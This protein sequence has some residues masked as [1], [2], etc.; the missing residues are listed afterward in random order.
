LAVS[1]LDRPSSLAALPDGRLLIAEHGGRIRI[2]DGGQLREASALELSVT[3]GDDDGG[4][5]IAVAPDFAAN[6]YV[7]V[8]YATRDN[9]GLRIG[10]VAR[11]REVAGTL[12]EPAVVLEGLPAEAG[13]PLMKVGPDGTLFVT[14]PARNAREA[15]DLSSLEGKVL[16][17]DAAGATPAN[18]PLRFSPVFSSGYTG[19]VDLDWHPTTRELWYAESSAQGVTIGIVRGGRAGEPLVRLDGMRSAG[20]AFHAGAA[21]SDWSGSLFLASLDEQCLLRVSGLSE[22]PPR[23]AVERVLSGFGR[24]AAVLSADDGLYFASSSNAA[25]GEG[26]PVGAVYRVRD[27]TSHR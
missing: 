4:V 12:G 10:R 8:S 24:I 19:R 23:P 2:A 16:R 15:A 17:F 6:R 11:Y 13:A 1:G 3:E 26:A 25:G 20:M 27:K 21:V 18:N 7:Y 5:S 9:A 14:A 22:S